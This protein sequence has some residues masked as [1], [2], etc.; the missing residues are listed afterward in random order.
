[1]TTHDRSSLGSLPS[2][3]P[4]ADMLIN[5]VA[6]SILLL[7]LTILTSA[8]ASQNLKLPKE[9]V[10]STAPLVMFCHGERIYADDPV[11]AAR[12]AFSNRPLLTPTD[13]TV[14]TGSYVITRRFVFGTQVKPRN[15]AGESRKAVVLPNSRFMNAIRSADPNRNFLFFIVSPDCVTTYRAAVASAEKLGF[16]TGWTALGKDQAV[17]IGGLHNESII[18]PKA[19]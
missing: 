14:E 7:V 10:G 19:Q 12:R 9:H 5:C 2:L 8:S 18:I 1:M 11:E 13:E 15:G 4:I 6:I 16:E 3:V 17:L